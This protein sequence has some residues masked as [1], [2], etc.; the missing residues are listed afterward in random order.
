MKNNKLIN[1]SLVTG[2]VCIL[3]FSPIMSTSFAQTIRDVPK[4]YEKESSVAAIS[5]VE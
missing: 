3:F 2:I 1:Y 5:L 4:I